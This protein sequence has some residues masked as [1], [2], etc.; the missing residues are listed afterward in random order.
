MAVTPDGKY[1]L[2]WE[3]R[4][5]AGNDISLL[6]MD[7]KRELT[8]L[9]GS[10]FNQGNADISPDGRWLAYQ[11]IETGQDQVYVRPF[12]DVNNGK[13]LISTDGGTKPVWSRNGRE[14]FYLGPDNTG[15]FV[16]PVQPTQTTFN[17][18]TA[19]KLF[20]ARYF[21]AI[22]ARSYDVSPDGKRFLMIKEVPVDSAGKNE[23]TASIIVVVNWLEELKRMVPVN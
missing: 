1:V 12:P 18:G 16:V 22:Q 5:A 8:S 11:S 6:E 17:W 9:M 14:L 19:V 13:W 3:Q 2:V 21:S 20:D 23:V 10:A 7:G 4:A 15:A